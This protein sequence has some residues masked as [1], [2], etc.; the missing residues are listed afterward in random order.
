MPV[1]WRYYIF[2]ASGSS[3]TSSFLVFFKI[4]HIL[5][6]CG[7]ISL[8]LSLSPDIL[9]PC[10]GIHAHILLRFQIGL[11]RC[12][13]PFSF[14]FELSSIFLSRYWIQFSIPVLSLLFYLAFDLYYLEHCPGICFKFIDLSPCGPSRFLEFF[15]EVFFIVLCATQFKS[16]LGFQLWSP[17]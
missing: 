9:A 14:Q 17:V 4:F 16:G 6:L 1:I 13:I 7:L 15:D 2:M 3:F 10:S 11:L 5:L 12:S 8:L